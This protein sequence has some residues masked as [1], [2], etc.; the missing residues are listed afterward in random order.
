MS[1]HMANGGTPISTL[2][3][4]LLAR[5][6]VWRLGVPARRRSAEC[7]RAKRALP[8]DAHPVPDR[9]RVARMNLDDGLN[10]NAFS[11]LAVGSMNV[12]PWSPGTLNQVSVRSALCRA[13]VR[14]GRRGA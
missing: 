4:P 6:R 11:L 14:R 10:L 8:A 12:A 3:R 5:S 9:R 13:R 7:V 2:P 1:L